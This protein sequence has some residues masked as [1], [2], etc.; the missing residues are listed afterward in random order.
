MHGVG[1]DVLVVE[2][3]RLGVE[4]EPPQGVAVAPVGP[5]RGHLEHRQVADDGA[6][7][8]AAQAERRHQV[9]R[10]QGGAGDAGEVGVLAV[11]EAERP[12]RLREER[13]VHPLRP[14]AA[15]LVALHLEQRRLRRARQAR[16][17][18][19]V[20][21]GL[22]QLVE[23][24]GGRRTRG[25]PR[26]RPSTSRRRESET[27]SSPSSSAEEEIADLDRDRPRSARPTR[28]LQRV[29]E[30]LLEHRPH[31][32]QRRAPLPARV[33]AR[34]GA[35]VQ[36]VA[37]VERQLQVVVAERVDHVDA[38]V[39]DEV[40]RFPRGEVGIPRAASEQRGHELAERSRHRQRHAI[41]GCVLL[42]DPDHSLLLP[43]RAC[44]KTRLMRV[45]AG[46]ESRGRLLWPACRPAGP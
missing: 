40:R 19:A 26:C 8:A 1:L 9:D 12:H 4:A 23:R 25:T 44:R 13:R 10:R 27:P 24:S 16:D 46:R 14:A 34:E 18:P 5:R 20:G 36:L 42:V 45:A 41:G 22:L 28:A 11:V 39:P 31:S 29:E 38:Q 6:A 7:P 37:E 43:G 30:G 3:G 17:R 33:D 15:V 21:I 32:E 2:V 35:V